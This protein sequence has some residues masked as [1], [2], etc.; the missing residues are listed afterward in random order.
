M[1]VVDFLEKKKRHVENLVGA[2]LELTEGE[3]VYFLSLDFFTSIAEI[4]KTY[5][6]GPYTILII[7]SN[8]I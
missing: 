6:L 1:F 2:C 5:L 3:K 8:H 7:T 4:S